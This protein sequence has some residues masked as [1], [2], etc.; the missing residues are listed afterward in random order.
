MKQKPFLILLSFLFF[1]GMAIAQMDPDDDLLTPPY[2]ASY[3]M[4]RDTGTTW[5]TLAIVKYNFYQGGKRINFTTRYFPNM[6][7]HVTKKY[8]TSKYFY[9]T[10]FK[11]VDSIQNFDSSGKLTFSYVYFRN[12]NGIADSVITSQAGNTTVTKRFRYVNKLL[13]EEYYLDPHTKNRN[14]TSLFNIFTR[15]VNGKVIYNKDNY[16]NYEKFSYIYDSLG[17]VSYIVDSLSYL[18]TYTFFDYSAPDYTTIEASSELPEPIVIFPNPFNSSITIQNNTFQG[19]VQIS[20]KDITG[21]TM[22]QVS[23]PSE[24]LFSGYTL[25]LDN[26]PTGMYTLNCNDGLKQGWSKIIKE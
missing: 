18:Q 26:L 13:F 15:D 6:K 12:A 8:S 24:E 14:D 5:D 11:N 4:M 23:T 1:S 19:K 22:H 3:Y 2:R 7:T 25:H 16:V 20:I 10:T 9:N 17:R 21:R